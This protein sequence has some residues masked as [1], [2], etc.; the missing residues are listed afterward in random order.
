MSEQ[1]A[2]EIGWDIW[3]EPPSL[4]VLTTS[5]VH[6]PILLA[7]LAWVH[8][9]LAQDP[10]FNDVT[11]GIVP[12]SHHG[13]RYLVIALRVPPGRDPEQVCKAAEARVDTLVERASMRE[14]VEFAARAP[15]SYDELVTE[16][17]D[18][19]KRSSSTA[20]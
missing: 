10:T 2:D 8:E 19:L 5:T 4:D 17:F 20:S 7:V 6:Q 16:Q 14:F 3:L 15:R 9:R 13:G 1:A 18:R 12:M 11:F